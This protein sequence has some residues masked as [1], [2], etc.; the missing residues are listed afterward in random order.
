[1]KLNLDKVPKHKLTVV[2][3]FINT[4]LYQ[5]GKLTYT[6]KENRKLVGAFKDTGLDEITQEDIKELRREMTN[7]LEKRIDT[8]NT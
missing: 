2:N 4:V 8:W 6:K 1:M 7:S 5:T 3:D